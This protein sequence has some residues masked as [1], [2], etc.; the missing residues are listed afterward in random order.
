MT[1]LGRREYA[2][3]GGGCG[4]QHG[5]DNTS[6][7]AARRWQWSCSHSARWPTQHAGAPRSRSAEQSPS[8]GSG[9]AASWRASARWSDPSR[10]GP[11]PAF[12]SKARATSTP[13]SRRG[14]EAATHPTWQSSLRPDKFR[15]S[16]ARAG[17]PR[18]TH[19]STYL[20]CGPSTGKIGSTLPASARNSM[21]SSSRLR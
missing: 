7:A 16:S 18:W 13:C 9:A 6:G 11:A 1:H 15:G 17:L 2:P 3:S 8:S 12:S 10:S 20:H 4:W 19:W 14:P 5:G 21:G